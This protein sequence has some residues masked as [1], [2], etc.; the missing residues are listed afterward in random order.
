MPPQF[1]SLY[2]GQ[3]IFIGPDGLLDSVGDLFV[4]YVI[5]V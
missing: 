1:P 2:R 5:L 4:G 3:E